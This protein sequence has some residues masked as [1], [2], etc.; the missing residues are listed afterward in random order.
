ML[1]DIDPPPIEPISLAETKAF[2]RVDH[3]ADDAL[4]QALIQTARESLESYLSIA[5]I[6]RSMQFSTSLEEC[7]SRVVKLPRWPVIS[8]DAVIVD[9]ESVSDPDIDLRKRPSSLVIERG[10]HVEAEFT[11]GYGEGADDVPAPLRQALLLLVARHYEK[12]EET[13]GA[14]PL[15]VDA[16]TM[17]Y[18][19]IGL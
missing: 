6:R 9:G 15:M 17:P 1:T 19:V 18:R 12:R 14:M 16:L 8:V 13:L 7:S 11:A 3:E 10:S 2:L 4:I 5:L